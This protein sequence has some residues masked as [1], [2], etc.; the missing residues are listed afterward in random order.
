M[1]KKQYIPLLTILTL[2]ACS[3]SLAAG[4]S[5]IK[6]Q[7]SYVHPDYVEVERLKDTKEVIVIQKKDIQEKGYTSLS[8]I[9]KDVPSINVGLT[10]QG[11]IDIRGQG[12]D[13]SARN[14]QVLLDGAPIT[15]VVNHPLK[16]NYDVVPVENIEKIEI[17]PGGGSLLY[18]SGA[19]GGVINIT[20]SLRTM[21]QVQNT[22]NTEWN[23]DGE[24]LNL[25]IGSKVNDKLTVTAGYSKINRNLYFKNTYRN[26]D[27]VYG[28]FRYD[29]DKNQRLTVR[30][31]HLEEDSRYIGNIPI[32][33]MLKEGKNYVPA[34][35]TVT[36]GLDADGHKITEKRRDYL[37][38]NRHLD[39]YNMTYESSLGSNWRFI[40]DFFYNKGV[41]QQH[42]YG[43]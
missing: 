19:S 22:L 1:K 28:G 18:G 42:R 17:I 9:L 14:L 21:N 36:V 39:S 15:S 5:T 31:S 43:R 20:T 11:D 10:G 6:L 7:D 33:K 26:S 8:D 3:S 2:L 40:G 24:K 37:N 38:G 27:Y 25:N 13:Q 41:L 4:P 29:I 35:Q 23:S 16:T 12:S 34:Y 32:S 30:A